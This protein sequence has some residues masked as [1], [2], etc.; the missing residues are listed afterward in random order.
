M[1][2]TAGIANDLNGQQATASPAVQSNQ[3]QQQVVP[4]RGG[5]HAFEKKRKWESTSIGGQSGRGCYECGS[6]DYSLASYPKKSRAMSGSDSLVWL[7]C[8]DSG[9][10]RPNSPKLVNPTLAVVE[11]RV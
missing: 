6:I 9:H 4:S 5:R 7:Y 11:T 8:K 3:T 2:T 10:I 1:E